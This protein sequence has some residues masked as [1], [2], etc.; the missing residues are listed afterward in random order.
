MSDD[1]AKTTKN[2]Y[3]NIVDSVMAF[4]SS[5]RSLE[6]FF[7]KKKLF[8][9]SFSNN[10]KIKNFISSVIE[11]VFWVECMTN[12]NSVEPDKGLSGRDCVKM[13]DKGDKN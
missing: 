4:V 5:H 7:N 3:S 8:L 13:A 10:E 11:T 1:V 9:N 2:A 6:S 12:C